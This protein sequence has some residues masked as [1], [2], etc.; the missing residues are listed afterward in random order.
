MM[1]STAGGTSGRTMRKGGGA[2]D[3]I[4][5]HTSGRV[6]PLKGTLPVRSS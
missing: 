4:F 1:A 6:I 5:T 2:C 3:A